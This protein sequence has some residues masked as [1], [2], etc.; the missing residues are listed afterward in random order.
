MPMQLVNVGVYVLKSTSSSIC[1]NVCRTFRI[2]N[3]GLSERCWRMLCTHIMQAIDFWLMEMAAVY[4]FWSPQV[5]YFENT[6]SSFGGT[7]V[8][9][10]LHSSSNVGRLIR[11]FSSWY[12]HLT[13]K[14]FLQVDMDPF[15]V[16]QKGLNQPYIVS[17]V[18]LDFSFLWNEYIFA[19]N[20][21]FVT[22]MCIYLYYIYIYIYNILYIHIDIIIDLLILF[23]Y[24]FTAKNWLFCKWSSNDTVKKRIF[25]IRTSR[26]NINI[27]IIYIYIYILYI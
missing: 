19:F 3:S 18:T 10:T 13:P 2:N 4:S 17:P 15:F 1:C 20:Y 12:W 14:T 25:K 21:F 26:Y 27:Y 22:C 9:T 7:F 8:R 11:L 23:F 6:C 16:L 5:S 24:R